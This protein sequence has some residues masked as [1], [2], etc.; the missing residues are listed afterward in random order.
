MTR[1][2][3]LGILLL[4]LLSGCTQIPEISCSTSFTALKSQNSK[5]FMCLNPGRK[6]VLRNDEASERLRSC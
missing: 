1:T 6:N 5:L 4:C 3:K 2:A